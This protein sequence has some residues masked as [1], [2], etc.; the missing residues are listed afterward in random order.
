MKYAVS[1][2]LFLISA[3]T[4]IGTISDWQA[5]GPRESMNE[6]SGAFPNVAD[7]VFAAS[8]GCISLEVIVSSRKIIEIRIL[9]NQSDRYDIRA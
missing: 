4:I 6:I 7:G 8:E 9:K 2:L 3:A 1:F 5:S